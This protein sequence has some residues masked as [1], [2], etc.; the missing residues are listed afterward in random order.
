[1]RKPVS[2]R[3]GFVLLAVTLS[4]LVHPTARALEYSSTENWYVMDREGW[5][6][7]DDARLVLTAYDLSNGPHLA[8]VPLEL[9]EWVGRDLTI[10]N[11]E[12][13]PTLDAD[14]I[15]YR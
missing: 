9:G 15:I 2:L 11:L 5:I 4:G 10:T 1:M 12:T 14:Q 8:A 6:R 7:T 13:F 3:L